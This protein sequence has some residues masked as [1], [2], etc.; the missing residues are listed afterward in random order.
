MP[1]ANSRARRPL[2]VRRDRGVRM[3]DVI[4]DETLFKTNGMCNQSTSRESFLDILMWPMLR[5]IGQLLL[6]RAS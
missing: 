6:S 3:A 2:S 1:A 4:G 5:R